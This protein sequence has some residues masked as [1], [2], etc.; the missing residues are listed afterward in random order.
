LISKTDNA[1]LF[2]RI[3]PLDFFNDFARGHVE[4][5]SQTKATINPT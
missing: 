5:V 4:S 3:K 2:F 1:Q